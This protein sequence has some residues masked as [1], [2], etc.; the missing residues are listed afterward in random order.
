MLK[1]IQFKG[2]KIYKMLD[3]P[4]AA[5]FLALLNLLKGKV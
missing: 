2:L 4:C 1:G 3:S 5:N